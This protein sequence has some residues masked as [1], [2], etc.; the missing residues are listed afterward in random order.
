MT[1]VTQEQLQEFT[2]Q[3]TEVLSSHFEMITRLAKIVSLTVPAVVTGM[4][5]REALD[6]LLDLL[7]EGS[8][9]AAHMK[10]ILTN[11]AISEGRV[12]AMPEDTQKSFDEM[13]AELHQMIQNIENDKEQP[14][15][16]QSN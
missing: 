12:I 2:N 15:N 14:K 1:P 8:D 10:E 11:I 16:E 7:L 3:L 5:T 9:D 4:L 6:T 13:L